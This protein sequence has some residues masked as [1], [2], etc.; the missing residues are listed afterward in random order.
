MKE[1]FEFPR[2]PATEPNI[3]SRKLVHGVGIND[4]WYKITTVLDGKEITCPYYS[5]WCAVLLRC[6]SKKEHL[7]GKA[8]SYKGCSVCDEWLTFSNFQKWMES[9]KWGGLQLDKDLIK[10]R[11]KVYSPE[12]CVFVSGK[13]NSLLTDSRSNRGNYK[14]GVYFLEK[15][16]NFRASC[17]NGNGKLKHLGTFPT[18]SQ[19]YEAYVHYKHALILKVASEQED[20]RVKNGL[21]LHA[22]LLLETLNEENETL[23][24][25]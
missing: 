21:I 17:S 25:K 20:E 24:Q 22:Q 1:A 18:E 19:A 3:K 23:S 11:N 14:K 7:R 2:I 9:Q 16:N 5:R 12:N 10:P 13:V 8:S 15:T 4:S 6:Y